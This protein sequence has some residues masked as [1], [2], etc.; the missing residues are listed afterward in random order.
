MPYC[1]SAFE[2]AD[3]ADKD[4]AGKDSDIAAGS[5]SVDIVIDLHI[6]AADIAAAGMG[7]SAG[8]GFDPE[9]AG[10]SY[11][12]GIDFDPEAADMDYSV[13]TD[14]DRIVA[15]DSVGQHSDCSADHCSRLDY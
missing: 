14:F 2:A 9:A 8:T 5:V 1:Y 3:T 12:A 10:M 11:S 13:G 6:E 15:A 4:F 7:C